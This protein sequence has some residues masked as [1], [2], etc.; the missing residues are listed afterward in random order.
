VGDLDKSP[1][2]VCIL[3]PERMFKRLTAS[4]YLRRIARDLDRLTTALERH[5]VLLAR[6][7]DKLAP[8]DPQTDR[9]LV[10]SD[11]GLSHLDPLDASLALDYVN[12]TTRDTGHIPDDEEILVYLADE[13]T[14]DLHKRLIER[15]AELERLSSWRR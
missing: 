7:T 9:A 2:L 15:D 1:R 3:G 10:A 6:L 4:I 13:K 14:T 12:R 5:A 8:E 11:T